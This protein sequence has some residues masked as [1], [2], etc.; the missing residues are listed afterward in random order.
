M[1][2]GWNKQGATITADV[3]GSERYTVTLKLNKRGLDGGCDCPASEGIDFCKHCV[4][5][6]L[7][8]RAEQ[9]EQARLAEV[10][11]EFKQKRNFIKWLNEAFSA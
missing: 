8:Y 6:A 5:V 4:A 11:T 2:V 1:V 9:A 7:M 3:E 10:R